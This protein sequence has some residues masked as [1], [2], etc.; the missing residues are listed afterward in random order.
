MSDTDPI[1]G[2]DL[3]TTAQAGVRT[4]IADALVALSAAGNGV[5]SIDVD[6]TN[7]VAVSA[8]Q[9]TGAGLLVLV[10]G[11][12]APTSGLTVTVPA[13]VRRVVVH[14]ASSQAASVGID[15]QT[16][17]VPVSAGDLALLVSDGAAVRAVS[18][19][20]GGGGGAGPQPYDL[21]VYAPGR[22]GVGAV[23]MRVVVPRAVALAA[24]APHSRAYA[25]TTA[26][27]EAVFEIRH[28][29]TAIG[30]VTFL[31]AGQTGV[32]A[33][34]APVDLIAGDRLEV[35]APTTQ[36]ATLA[37]VSLTLACTR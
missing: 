9:W 17:P 30:T 25:A 12:P 23:V 18:G 27:A 20:G 37:D 32:F 16:G 36:D 19:G 10:D 1:L 15:G 8:A 22:P 7:A 26:T 13:T 4:T 24:G 11:T 14:N 34:A 21:A 31:A 28:N 35:V 3:P 5:V 29:G 2:F 6:D 33:V